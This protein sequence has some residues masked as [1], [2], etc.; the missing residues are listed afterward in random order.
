MKATIDRFEGNFAVI[1]LE[2]RETQKIPKSLLPPC[3]KEGD[4]L[5]I[6][7]GFFHMD[8]CETDKR[9][10]EIEKLMQEVWEE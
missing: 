10:E 2:N 1:E 6:V 8:T 3:A 9:K 4:V 7:D 5:D